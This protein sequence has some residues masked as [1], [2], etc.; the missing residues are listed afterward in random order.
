MLQGDAGILRGS[1][2]LQYQGNIESVLD[3]LDV[4]PAKQGLEVITADVLAP[5]GDMALGQIPFAPTVVIQIHGKAQRMVS[6]IHG[7]TDVVVDPRP[8]TAHIKLE[9]LRTVAGF[10]DPLQP[11]LTA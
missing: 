3:A 1:N 10:G 7:T 5:R 11:R 9:N 8:V 2:A 4:I 6:G